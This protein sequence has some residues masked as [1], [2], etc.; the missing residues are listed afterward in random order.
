M[1]D[2]A[3][4]RKRRR[5]RSGSKPEKAERLTGTVKF[6]GHKGWGFVTPDKDLPPVENSDGEEDRD[7]FIHY[8][9]ITGMG[10][11]TLREGDRV[12][13]DLERTRKGYCAKALR[14]LDDK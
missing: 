12:I 1:E 6:F 4:S 5:T 8:S 11:R 7:V 2:L 10:F 13:F 9:D 14:L 3:A